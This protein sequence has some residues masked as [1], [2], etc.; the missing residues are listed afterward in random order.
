V[1]DNQ[2]LSLAREIY[3]LGIIPFNTNIVMKTTEDRQN[4]GQDVLNYIERIIR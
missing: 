1:I 3:R 4:L 2:D